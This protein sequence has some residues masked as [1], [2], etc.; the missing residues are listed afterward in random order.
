MA[1]SAFSVTMRRTSRPARAPPAAM[2]NSR[3]AITCCASKPSSADLA[4]SEANVSV[5]GMRRSGG[6][7][8]TGSIA[9]W[10]PVR[11]RLPRRA[12]AAFH[13]LLNHATGDLALAHDD[14]GGPIGSQRVH[15]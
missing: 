11:W 12:R 15:L 10:F 6:T 13:H 5:I 3:K 2:R 7:L 1:T 9:G 14:G 4:I 8:T